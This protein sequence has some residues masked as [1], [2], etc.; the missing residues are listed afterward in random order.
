[1]QNKITT[2]RVGT[3]AINT[4]SDPNLAARFEVTVVAKNIPELLR[5]A[6]VRPEIGFKVAQPS[7]LADLVDKAGTLLVRER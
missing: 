3:G 7:P 2:Q 5:D 1:M 6:W 4:A